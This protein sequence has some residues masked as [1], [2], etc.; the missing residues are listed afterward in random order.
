MD[1]AVPALSCSEAIE[2]VSQTRLLRTHRCCNARRPITAFPVI[3]VLEAKSPTGWVWNRLPLVL[4]YSRHYRIT[5]EELAFLNEKTSSQKRDPPKGFEGSRQTSL[6]G[7][8][9]TCQFGSDIEIS[10]KA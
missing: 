2:I 10:R 6:F 1:G 7:Q 4:A 8:W 9:L 5:D 3:Q